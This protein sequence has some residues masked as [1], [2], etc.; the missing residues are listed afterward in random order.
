MA[1]SKDKPK[2]KTEDKAGLERTLARV[3]ITVPTAT[4]MLNVGAAECGRMAGEILAIGLADDIGQPAEV[5]MSL[6]AAM[7]EANYARLRNLLT[8]SAK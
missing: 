2:A 3:G 4:I 6:R 7:G 5:L 1:K 8:E